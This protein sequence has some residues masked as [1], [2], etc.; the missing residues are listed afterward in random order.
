MT[1]KVLVCGAGG[2]LGREIK[3]IEKNE[4]DY[5][6][7]DHS[8]LDITS[9]EAIINFVLQH[10][11]GVI[12]NCVGYTQVDEAED[13]FE[14]A[15]QVNYLAVKNLAEVCAELDIYLIH[16]STDYVFDGTKKQ[17]YKEE[18]TPNPQTI[19]GKTK[20]AGEKAIQE[21]LNNYLI[22]RISWLYSAYGNNF[23]KTIQRLSSEKSELKVVSDQIGSPTYAYDLAKFIIYFIEEKYYK[24][25]QGIYHFANKGAVSWYEFA[26]EIVSLLDN[27]CEIKSCLSEEYPVKAVRPKYSVLDTEKLQKDF[28]YQVSNWRD[29]L[30]GFLK[31]ELL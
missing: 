29:S 6:Y 25:K 18:D 24:T 12:V 31:S 16:I 26:K 4:A 28:N 13:N 23:V 11:I 14:M 1:K 7:T 10:K 9:K 8:E 2:Q 20:L 19:Y 27:D 21:Q 15:N 3:A 5:L 30:L 17:P 22:V